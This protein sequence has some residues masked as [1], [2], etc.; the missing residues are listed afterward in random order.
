MPNKRDRIRILKDIAKYAE[1]VDR[2]S[3]LSLILNTE[4][5]ISSLALTYYLEALPIYQPEHPDSLDTSKNPATFNS[6]WEIVLRIANIVRYSFADKA[7]L[8]VK[9][10]LIQQ[11]NIW[12]RRIIRAR[13]S[14]PRNLPP[15]ETYI[16]KGDKDGYTLWGWDRQ[17]DTGFVKATWQLGL[18]LRVYPLSKALSKVN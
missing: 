13:M 4:N 5:L 9:L 3:Y 11:S 6:N 10:A 7:E 1:S 15:S 16:K 18:N 2:P 12:L 14:C 17:S 8:R